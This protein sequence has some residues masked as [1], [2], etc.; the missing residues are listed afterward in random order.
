MAGLKATLTVGEQAVECRATDLSR[1]GVALEGS[2]GSLAATH[3]VVSLQSNS[4]ELRF[5]ARG[6]VAYVSLDEETGRQ[7]LGLE[8]E[9]IDGDQ[10]EN[11]EL[12]I[13]RVI[14][15]MGPGPL[16]ELKRDASV[17]E[18]RAAL[19]KIPL[20]HKITAAQRAL[21]LER[22]FLRHDDS[23]QVI[24]ALCRNPQ[25]TLPEV[26]EILRLPTLL[27][28]TLELL[29]RDPRWTSNEE[30]VVIIAT[31]PRVTFQ[32]AERL[33]GTLDIVAIRKIIRRP[34]L[35]PAIKTK[36]VQSIPHKRLQGW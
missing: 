28:T 9:S 16:A 27:P 26:I 2:F 1:R 4:E 22:S 12:L 6:R 17:E 3:A 23:S 34:G 14:E 20:A 29:S 8:F 15:G 19:G 24:E 11:L 18:I 13:S 7:R 21:P 25:L 36:L 35:H 5:V 10:V 30:V 32:V 31:H 33:V